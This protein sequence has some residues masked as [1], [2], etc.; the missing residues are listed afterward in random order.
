MTTESVCLLIN[1][2][3]GM[4]SLFLFLQGDPGLAGLTGLPGPLGRKVSLLLVLEIEDSKGEL[5]EFK[6]TSEERQ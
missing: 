1:W 4:Y 6:Y 5:T 3:S 2:Q